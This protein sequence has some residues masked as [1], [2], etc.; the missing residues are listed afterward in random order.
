[1]VVFD[2]RSEIDPLAGVRHWERALRLEPVID[3]G[4]PP[5]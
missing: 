5:V 2:A 4:S 3:F 1:V